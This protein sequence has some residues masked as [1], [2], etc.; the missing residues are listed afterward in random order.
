VRRQGVFA[1]E[2]SII[3]SSSASLPTHPVDE[4][5][6]VASILRDEVTTPTSET[7]EH[8]G[9]G[10]GPKERQRSCKTTCRRSLWCVQVVVSFF[11]FA[12]FFLLVKSWF[13]QIKARQKDCIKQYKKATLN[14]YKAWDQHRS[15]PLSSANYVRVDPVRR[16]CAAA[17][18]PFARVLPVTPPVTLRTR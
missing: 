16:L 13:C 18:D 12:I 3:Q 10:W 15:Q 4:G 11:H 5:D 8:R 6:G 7:S 9:R 17:P 2:G 1:G 14:L